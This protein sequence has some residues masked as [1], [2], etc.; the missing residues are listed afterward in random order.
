MSGK[1][2]LDGQPPS[3][4]RASALAGKRIMWRVKG[5]LP[6]EP[7]YVSGSTLDILDIRFVSSLSGKYYA[8]DDIDYR[9]L[10]G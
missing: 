10:Q 6:Y 7:G 4:A 5:T 8:I 3:V 2:T 1:D 9:V